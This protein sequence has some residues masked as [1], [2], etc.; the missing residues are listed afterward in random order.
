MPKKKKK[1]TS[2]YTLLKPLTREDCFHTLRRR[3]LNLF[4]SPIRKFYVVKTLFQTGEARE[5]WPPTCSAIFPRRSKFINQV[6]QLKT[7][8]HQKYG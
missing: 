1:K 5:K 4:P 8:I 3:R 6:L 7:T 2:V